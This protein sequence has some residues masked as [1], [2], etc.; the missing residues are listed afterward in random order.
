MFQ[1][2]SNRI[3]SLQ[4]KSSKA[5][6]TRNRHDAF[7]KQHLAALLKPYGEVFTSHKITSETREVDLWFIPRVN[8]E[9]ERR[10]LGLLGQMLHRPSAFEPFRNAV[11]IDEID[12]CL[13]KL[14]FLK[15]ELRREARREKRRFRATDR[16]QLWILSP[17]LSDATLQKFEAK[18]RRGWEQGVYFLPPGLPGRL[19]ATHKLPVSPRT[20]LLRLMAR[21]SVQEQA[22]AELLALPA[23]NPFKRQTIEHLAILQIQL[24][25]GQNLGVD[26][27]GLMM[28]LTPVYEQWRQAAVEE[29]L[30]KGEQ[31]GSANTVL[32]LLPRRV[33]A[34]P[35]ALQE[36]I[37]GISLSKLEELTE[38]LMDFES[39]NDLI[40]WLEAHGSN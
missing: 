16:P 8:S 12:N 32:R 4:Y 18:P 1:L 27:R 25:M 37:R 23:S 21:G 14:N 13:G 5:P 33:G 34:L 24:Q 20:L 7:A 6:M 40:A 31:R 26:E 30:V 35:N 2:R 10:V 29:G 19:V 3:Q 28:N 15:E 17:T 11:S 22:I 36:T 38:A 9:V 39:M